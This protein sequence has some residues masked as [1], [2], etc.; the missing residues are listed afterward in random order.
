[1]NLTHTPSLLLREKDRLGLLALLQQYLS[2]VTVWA[3]GSRLNGQAHEASD[4]D[5]VLRTPDLR[6]I[7]LDRLAQFKDALRES[8]IPILVQ[9][10]DWARLPPAFHAEILKQYLVLKTGMTS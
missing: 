8:N 10:H 2:D 7:L 5:I 3:Y 9:V 1:M 4:L 6:P